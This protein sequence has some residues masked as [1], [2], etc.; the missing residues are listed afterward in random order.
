[1]NQGQLSLFPPIGV[2]I[3]N[4]SKTKTHENNPS[5]ISLQAISKIAVD[6]IIDV[7]WKIGEQSTNGIEISVLNRILTLIKV[8]N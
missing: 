1:L 3:P 6:D 7:R 8:G 4:T 2:L 5:D